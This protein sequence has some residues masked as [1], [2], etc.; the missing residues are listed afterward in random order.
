MDKAG[1]ISTPVFVISAPMEFWSLPCAAFHSLGSY[2]NIGFL[3]HLL[4][5]HGQPNK[6]LGTFLPIRKR[7]PLDSYDLS[8]RW[9]RAHPPI[10]VG[11]FLT[12]RVLNIEYVARKFKPLWRANK[13]F[14][15]HDVGKNKAVFTFHDNIDRERVLANGPWMYDKYLVILEKLDGDTP[16]TSLR[17]IE[18]PIWL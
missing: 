3:H 7:R 11:R 10:L 18:T 17:L 9:R 8:T 15:I 4:S 12:K 13:G 16:I 2:A 6:P 1:L 14:K 5:P